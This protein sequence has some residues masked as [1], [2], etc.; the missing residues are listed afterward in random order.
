MKKSDRYR[1]PTFV[2]AAA[3]VKPNIA[4]IMGPTIWYPRSPMRSLMRDIASETAAAQTYGGPTSKRVF[5]RLR[6]KVLTRVGMNEVTA[7]AL[8]FVMIMSL[9]WLV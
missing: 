9:E 5:T 6:P 2:V 8:V 3:K 7:P 4:P 1:A